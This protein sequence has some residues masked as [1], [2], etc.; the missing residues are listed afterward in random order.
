MLEPAAS[1]LAPVHVLGVQPARDVEPRDAANE[2]ALGDPSLLV[3]GDLGICEGRDTDAG[4]AAPALQYGVTEAEDRELTLDVGV[5]V[6]ERGGREQQ[7]ALGFLREPRL[8]EGVPIGV[9]EGESHDPVARAAGGAE[10]MLQV[11]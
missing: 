11:T 1:P 5:V 3:L 6:L 4:F 10:A 8:S 9:A 7:Y 2:E